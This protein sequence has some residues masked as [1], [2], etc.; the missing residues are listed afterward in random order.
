MKE[1]L[2]AAKA[3]VESLKEGKSDLEGKLKAATDR[4]NEVTQELSKAQTEHQGLVKSLVDNITAANDAIIGS[5]SSLLLFL[6]VILDCGVSN[7]LVSDFRI[8]PGS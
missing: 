2:D 7:H 4:S 6:F 5:F 3:A 8:L 1:E